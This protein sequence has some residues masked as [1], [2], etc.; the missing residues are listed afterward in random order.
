MQQRARVDRTKKFLRTILEECDEVL[1]DDLGLEAVPETIQDIPYAR[2]I[3]LSGNTLHHLDGRFHVVLALQRLHFCRNQLR[4]VE[5]SIT[6]A[7]S[8][9]VSSATCLRL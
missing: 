8:L 5:P 2:S 7:I 6:E 9:Q 3:N 1:W 4:I